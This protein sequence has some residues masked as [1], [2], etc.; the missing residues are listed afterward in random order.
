MGCWH[1]RLKRSI[2]HVR[3][4]RTLQQLVPNQPHRNHNYYAVAAQVYHTHNQ[5]KGLAHQKLL[6]YGSVAGVVE[7]VC[8]LKNHKAIKRNHTNNQL[9]VCHACS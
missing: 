4:Q 9:W 1:V 8:E 5:N 7:P 6:T 2:S 3:I